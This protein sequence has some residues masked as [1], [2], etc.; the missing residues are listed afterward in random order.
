MTLIIQQLLVFPFLESLLSYFLSTSESQYLLLSKNLLSICTLSEFSCG[1]H[2]S[3]K[4][5]PMP[6]LHDNHTRDYW[7][8][9]DYRIFF[10]YKRD[11]K[12]LQNGLDNAQVPHNVLDQQ[13]D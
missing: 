10:L 7:F 12:L 8:S 11:T 9:F 5:A 13:I 2:Q 1:S 3:L 4:K 6:L